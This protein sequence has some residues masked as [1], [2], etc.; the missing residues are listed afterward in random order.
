MKTLEEFEIEEAAP[1]HMMQHK[2]G[3]K[4]VAMYDELEPNCCAWHPDIVPSE[5][6]LAALAAHSFVEGCT[7]WKIPKMSRTKQAA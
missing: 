3:W 1:L 4:L 2:E 6:W 7:F 5:T